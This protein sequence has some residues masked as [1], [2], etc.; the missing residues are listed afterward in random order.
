M[1]KIPKM[2]PNLNTLRFGSDPG[3]ALDKNDVETKK[4]YLLKEYTIGDDFIAHYSSMQM[5]K[6]LSIIS[7]K[8]KGY[9]LKV[10]YI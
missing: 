10:L 2:W 1:F 8:A 6:Y 9:F 7:P 4:K 3:L 5:L